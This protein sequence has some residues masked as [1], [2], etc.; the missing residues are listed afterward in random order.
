MRN[1]SSKLSFPHVIVGAATS[2]TQEALAL[3]RQVEEVLPCNVVNSSASTRP[4]PGTHDGETVG[5]FHIRSPGQLG[6]PADAIARAF[7]MDG[8]PG[9][10]FWHR[11]FS[12]DETGA[13]E[14]SLP[15]FTT[16][17]EPALRRLATE[18]P[19]GVVSSLAG[20]RHIAFAQST[21][22]PEVAAFV[23]FSLVIR[24]EVD[25]EEVLAAPCRAG[26]V[27]FEVSLNQ[28]VT[29]ASMRGAGAAAALVEFV[30]D[31]VQ[32]EL[33]AALARLKPV[34]DAAGLTLVGNVCVSTRRDS[35]ATLM[36][37]SLL[38]AALTHAMLA[39]A[40]SAEMPSFAVGIEFDGN[41][42]N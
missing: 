5:Y 36:V 20:S 2:A 31:V 3:H 33:E 6:R 38:E 26:G 34:A 13:L 24:P 16:L 10:T 40:H 8:A 29:R 42:V 14:E 30:V 35:Q 22:S 28:L 1:R 18:A 37:Q 39:L 21:Q 32:A 7:S 41:T 27:R 19:L 17:D 4:L 9:E 12:F 11:T 25:A 15:L 23:D